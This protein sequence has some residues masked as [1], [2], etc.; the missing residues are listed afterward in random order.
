[1]FFVKR[2][3]KNYVPSVV[4]SLIVGMISIITLF[5]TYKGFLGFSVDFI[6]ILIYYIALFIMLITKNKVI[7][8]EKFKGENASLLFLV[9]ILGV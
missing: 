4:I 2:E 7:D 8:S 1:M 3:I 6:N 9:T 5:Y